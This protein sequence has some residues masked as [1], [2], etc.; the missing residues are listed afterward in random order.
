MVEAIKKVLDSKVQNIDSIVANQQRTED[1]MDIFMA[2]MS[3]KATKYR[4][5]KST[6]KGWRKRLI[7]WKDKTS[8]EPHDKTAEETRKC[9]EEKM[10]EIIDTVK[11]QLR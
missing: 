2:S 8:I 4:V 7:H 11:N 10:E 1:K 5:S 3:K 9:V 6:R